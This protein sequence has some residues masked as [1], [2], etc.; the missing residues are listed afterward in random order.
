M[1]DDD[2]HCYADAAGLVPCEHTS[3]V[4][5]APDCGCQDIEPAGYRAADHIP[6]KPFEIGDEVRIEGYPGC[7]SRYTAVIREKDGPFTVVEH[8]MGREMVRVSSLAHA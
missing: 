3:T 1:A 6:K 5:G 2:R 8:G 4:Y 7:Y